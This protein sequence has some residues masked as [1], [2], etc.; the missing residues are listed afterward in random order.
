[1]A[2]NFSKLKILVVDDFN[3]MRRNMQRMLEGFGAKDIDAAGSAVGAIKKIEENRYDIIIC[4][5]NL[6]EGKNGQQ[7]LEEIKYRKLF[8]N[9]GVFM[10]VTAEMG[11]DMVLGAMDYKPD[12]YLT[13]PFVA[14]VLKKR[15]EKQIAKKE[16][17]SEIEKALEAKSYTRALSLC[18]AQ[19]AMAPRNASEF[20]KIKIDAL[21]ALG[22]LDQ[23]QALVAS[24]LELRSVPWAQFEQGKIEFMRGNY[25]MARDTFQNIVDHNKLFMEAYDW[26]ADA[27]QKLGDGH[28]A[29]EILNEAIRLSPRSL[30]RQRELG[31]VAY[32]NKDFSA[33]ERSYRSAVRL[34]KDSVLKSSDDFTSLARSQASNGSELEALKTLQKA[35][36]EF[37][38]EPSIQAQTAVVE[39]IVYQQMG[40]PEDARRALESAGAD[41][42]KTIPIQITIDL[43]RSHLQRGDQ[44]QAVALLKEALKNYYEDAEVVAR[45]EAMFEEF[46]QKQ[47]ATNMVAS[48]REEM[49]AINNQGVALV[50]AGKLDEALGLFLKAADGLP[51]NRTVNLNAAQVLIMH[52]QQKGVDKRYLNKANDFL[53]RVRNI[54]PGNEK[55]H[56]LMAMLGQMQ[57]Q[58]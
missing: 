36:D 49:T 5:Y 15:L 10:M 13:K 16:Q 44:E 32:Q 55:Y 51:R 40:R 20:L 33:A 45:I 17:F 53:E 23:A 30:N 19:L 52:L 6:G 57:E 38:D 26:L 31:E 7:I 28:Q 35:R 8:S 18:D 2:V 42:V 25:V 47:E 11:Q 43:A 56:T 21:I 37:K 14:G 1:M 22:D 54:D 29:Q 27:H 3:E 9:S 12:D 34:S 41:A 39:S 58:S 50:K 48:A 4:D 24:I 46:G